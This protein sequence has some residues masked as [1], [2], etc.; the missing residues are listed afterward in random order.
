MKTETY[1]LASTGLAL[2]ELIVGYI[3]DVFGF[4]YQYVNLSIHAVIG[5]L[6]FIFSIISYAR[7]NES[8]MKR[9]LLSTIILIVIAAIL[10]FIYI[11]YGNVIISIIHFIF[12]LGVL[13]NLSVAYGFI[14]GKRYK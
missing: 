4:G 7:V 12:A 14:I 5:I 6:L 11:I 1:I 8:F 9:L 3:V 2:L 13:S 10:G